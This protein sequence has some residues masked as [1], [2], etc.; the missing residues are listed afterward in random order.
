MHKHDTTTQDLSIST[1]ND[2]ASS[3]TNLEGAG[4]QTSSDVDANINTRGF[5]TS[6]DVDSNIIARGYQTSSQVTTN[7]NGKGLYSDISGH[8][9]DDTVLQVKKLGENAFTNIQMRNS[10]DAISL[11]GKRITLLKGTS[12]AIMDLPIADQPQTSPFAG[13]NFV[14]GNDNTM[15]RGS[16]AAQIA[17][18]TSSGSITLDNGLTISGNDT[19][20]TDL[21]FIFTTYI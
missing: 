18:T 16:V 4:Y 2:H 14:D 17:S 1:L 6:S 8:S 10:Y 15:F 3:I 12:S 21:H 20:T 7:I 9:T 19:F 13:L 11:S 5:Q